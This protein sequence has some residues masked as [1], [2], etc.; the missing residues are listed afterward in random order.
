MQ[1]NS[2]ELLKL[3]TDKWL[4]HNSVHKAKLLWPPYNSI[5]AIHFFSFFSYLLFYSYVTVC[6]V[7]IIYKCEYTELNWTELPLGVVALTNGF[8]ADLT[9]VVPQRIT[10]ETLV[11]SYFMILFYLELD[12]V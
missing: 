12:S 5:K 4:F 3:T 6:S 1:T 7:N 10:Y 11:I 2:A 8:K 9:Q